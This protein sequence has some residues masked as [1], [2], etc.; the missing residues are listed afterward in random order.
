MDNVIEG[1]VSVKTK[2]FRGLEF[3]HTSQ[4]DCVCLCVCGYRYFLLW[5]VLQGLATAGDI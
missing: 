1:R 2:F 5:Y 3:I 4:S